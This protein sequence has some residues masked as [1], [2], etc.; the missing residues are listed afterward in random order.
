[1]VARPPSALMGTDYLGIVH[2]ASPMQLAPGVA[3]FAPDIGLQAGQLLPSLISDEVDTAPSGFTGLVLASTP[4]VKAEDGTAGTS[5]AGLWVS[6]TGSRVFDAGTFGWSWGLDPRYAAGAPDFPADEFGQLTARI[7]AWEGSQPDPEATVPVSLPARFVVIAATPSTMTVASR[8]VQRLQRRGVL[9]FSI[10]PG[11]AGV[12]KLEVQ[13]TFN[14]KP[15]ALG[16]LRRLRKLGFHAKL[17]VTRAARS[18][19]PGA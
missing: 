9:G 13:R 16:V 14:V 6:P 10:V 7:L 15:A 3:A 2:G 17:E 8:V 12:G 1:M 19:V 11:A 4:V 18:D 5:D